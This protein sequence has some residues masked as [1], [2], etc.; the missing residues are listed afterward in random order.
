MPDEA[1]SQSQDNS[2]RQDCLIGSP[3]DGVVFISGDETE[4]TVSYQ[5]WLS[6]L[7]KPK[8]YYYEINSGDI[9][10]IK[11]IFNR[12]ARVY[13]TLATFE[14]NVK[15]DWIEAIDQYQG[16]FNQIY[17]N[18]IADYVDEYQP[19]IY[20]VSIGVDEPSFKPEDLYTQNIHTLQDVK[21]IIYEILNDSQNFTTVLSKR[22]VETREQIYKTELQMFENFP[23]LN[24]RFSVRC[25]TNESD[26]DS[27]IKNKKLLYYNG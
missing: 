25:I 5:N 9:F 15:T 23:R 4:K 20:M 11:A 7:A 22:N 16:Y 3:A 19:E 21:A 1:F 27:Y 2:G 18:T 12:Y 26:I 8:P 14:C 24:L 6:T 13:Y 10:D 17:K